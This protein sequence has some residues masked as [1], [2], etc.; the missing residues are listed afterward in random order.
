[1]SAIPFPRVSAALAVAAFSALPAL[2]QAGSG[3]IASGSSKGLSWT[4]SH[5]LVGVGST[6]TASLPGDPSYW[7]AYPR[8]GG[9]VGLVTQISPTL[10]GSCTGTLLADRVSVLTAAHCVS[11]GAGTP[12]PIGTTVF[13][14]PEGGLSTTASIFASTEV[15][16]IEASQWFVRG[17]Y[18]GQVLDQNDIAVIRLSAPAPDWVPSYDFD[19]TGA[20]LLGSNFDVAGYGRLG[21]G[22]TGSTQVTGR[23]RSGDN[24][25]DFR[26]GDADFGGFFTGGFFGTADIGWSIVSDFDNGSATNDAGCRLAAALG[27]GGGDKFCNTGLGSTES[28][29]AQGDSGGP[30][31][32]GGTITAVNSYIVSFENLGDVDAAL[33]SSF[34][35]FSGYVPTYLHAEFIR[36]S[37]VPEPGTWMMLVAGLSGVAFV[38]RRRRPAPR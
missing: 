16:R 7:P 12:G 6:G 3:T 32:I 21:S 18:T 27:L 1:M 9:V 15:T 11:E 8:D 38:A 30:N 25:Y 14:Q 22:A 24:R 10:A 5:A 29:V 23:L 37:M 4:A 35:E 31:F 33:N 13:F 19:T 26:W 34:G 2:A 28:G 20:G 36:A 17:G